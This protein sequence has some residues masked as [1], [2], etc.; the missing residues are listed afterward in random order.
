MIRV[1]TKALIDFEHSV[2]VQISFEILNSKSRQFWT[3]ILMSCI[4]GCSSSGYRLKIDRLVEKISAKKRRT[5]IWVVRRKTVALRHL[6]HRNCK[7][8]NHTFFHIS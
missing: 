8:F 2:R 3:K 4:E 1:K 7:I 5:S 6:Y